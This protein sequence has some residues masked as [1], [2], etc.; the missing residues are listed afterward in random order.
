MKVLLV[1]PLGF[2]I[3]P[4]VTTYAGIERL[5]WE[6]SRELVRL[7][8]DV[9]V[10]GHSDSIF[11]EGVN[12]W[13]TK[14]EANDFSMG[15]VHQFQEYHGDIRRSNF[16]VIQDF[17]HQ[18]LISRKMPNMPTLNLF[19]HAPALARYEKA[20]Y[21]IVALSQWAQREFRRVYGQ[22]AIYQQSIVVD[23]EL[24]SPIPD[25]K[26]N[27]RFLSVGRMGEEKGNLRAIKLCK[28][29]NV[30]LDVITA[31]GTEVT[32]GSPY[33]KYEQDCIDEADGEQIRIFWQNDYTE[34]EKIA[35][36]Q[37]HK[38]LIYL[39]DHPEVTNHKVQECLLC[40][41]PVIVPAIG[42][43]TEIVTN[44]VDGFLC[45]DEGEFALAVNSVDKLNPM[46]K[47]EDTKNKYSVSNV[48]E[49]YLPLYKAVGTG[50][51]W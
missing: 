32:P 37:N 46:A 10:S 20:P 30:P 34:K 29:L 22:E 2:A 45:R 14:P 41:M 38:A 48:V 35:M 42:A 23:T 36:M 21:N 8:H 7:G 49:N 26:R 39:T 4:G 9:T 6:Y 33:T 17:S 1:S 43:L 47:Y 15:E 27:D 13:K 18:H 28:A 11:P 51:R 12:V 16:N 3:Q 31:R 19:W 50:A 24:Y 5:V 44:G 40:G 25:I